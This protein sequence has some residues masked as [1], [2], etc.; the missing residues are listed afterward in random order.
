MLGNTINPPCW[1]CGDDTRRIAGSVGGTIEPPAELPTAGELLTPPPIE[2]SV[3]G[4]REA[5]GG[6]R[7]ECDGSRVDVSDNVG[8]VG[9]LTEGSVGGCGWWWP[10]CGSGGDSC[11]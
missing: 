11:R 7:S 2:G 1:G 8:N 6:D 4:A 9:A 3:G 5:P 10:T